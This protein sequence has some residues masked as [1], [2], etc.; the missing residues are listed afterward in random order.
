[1][2]RHPSSGPSP[3]R[4][5]HF[6]IDFDFR[7]KNPARTRA[8]ADEIA[9]EI[10]TRDVKDLWTPAERI[11]AEPP[12]GEPLAALLA[13]CAA[14]LALGLTRSSRAYLL[15]AAD[16]LQSRLEQPGL[17]LE[18]AVLA[19]A[20]FLRFFQSRLPAFEGGEITR[21]FI[22]YLPP[23]SNLVHSHDARHPGLYF[24]LIHW[25]LLQSGFSVWAVR[26]V[27]LAFSAAAV[28]LAGLVVRRHAGR[29]PALAAMALLAASPVFLRLS[30]E[31][32]DFS[33]FVMLALA[34][35]LFYQRALDTAARSDK[36]L[37][38]LSAGLC[39]LS[40]YAA[41]V[42]F[43]ALALHAGW[44][45]ER[46]RRLA[47]PLGL[48]L[49]IGSPAAA[50]LL[51]MLPRELAEKRLAV[52]AQVHL[53]GGGGLGELARS[54]AEELFTRRLWPLVLAAAALAL[55]CHRRRLA[56]R[57][58]IAVVVACNLALL[59][60]ASLFRMKPYYAV[61]LQVAVILL[62]AS[63]VEPLPPDA[64]PSPG[65]YARR[66]A[67]P[68]A[69]AV[70]GAAFAFELHRDWE[71]LYVQSANFRGSIQTPLELVKR[72]GGTTVI[73]EVGHDKVSIA[74]HFFQK[75]F[76]SWA[77]FHRLGPGRRPCAVRDGSLLCCDEGS[78]RC[79]H[80]LS[81]GLTLPPDWKALAVPK[82][83]ALL[84]KGPA[85]FLYDS[86]YPNEPLRAHLDK[87][88]SARSLEGRYRLYSCP[89]RKPARE[90]L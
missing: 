47:W 18:A 38:A 33:L 73:S 11:P 76:E 90:K 59:G 20:L 37:L 2:L 30:R 36:V 40:S 32:G 46:R 28:A 51:L 86:S 89:A 70:L 17:L 52:S 45:L 67:P 84:T 14:V 24:A 75:P 56:A 49:L 44:D 4:S 81:E 34:A 35:L 48:A 71:S 39:L 7:L 19:G 9:R 12:S 29:G 65:A 53:W 6:A 22:A 41:V 42:V 10:Q 72:D 5:R 55:A 61:F 87:A 60:G 23:L 82:L 16:G 27:G 25:P 79:I 74:Y 69:L 78:A 43:A 64:A 88:C 68:L 13:L 31:I 62:I 57:G 58:P 1:V 26:A 83:D 77:N 3:R 63:L 50:Q 15:A 54:T 21:L 8:C 80:V 66:L 85:H